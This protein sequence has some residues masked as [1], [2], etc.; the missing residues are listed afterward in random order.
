ME[1]LEREAELDELIGAID[2]AAAGGGRLVAIEGTAGIGKTQLLA[3]ARE[4]AAG[5]GLRVLAAR[6]TE[7][8]RAFAYGVVR[9]L[10]EPVV[11]RADATDRAWLLSGSAAHAE[12]VL[13]RPGSA[14][15]GSSADAA[16][17]LLHGLYWVTVNLA[18]RTPLLIAVD[19]AHWSDA[20]SL[21]W[22]AY[23]ANRLEGLPVAVVAATRPAAADADAALADV[24]ADQATIA[25]RPRPLSKAAA[26]QLASA[27]LEHSAIERIGDAAHDATGGNPLLLGEL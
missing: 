13:T 15:A 21:R 14:G 9:Q 5:A 11:A 16:F 8:E 19:D 6:G 17:A 25:I 24:L 7:L 10:L 12:P 3:A 2:A 27:R 1:L 20:P 23:V 18:E 22:L 4:H 26:A